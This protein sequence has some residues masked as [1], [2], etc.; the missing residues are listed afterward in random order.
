MSKVWRTLS[1]YPENEVAIYDHD[2]NEHDYLDFQE[3]RY[4]EVTKPVRFFLEKRI[5]RFNLDFVA[6]ST[7]H[8]KLA[9][10]RACNLLREIAGECI[11]F[12]PCVIQNG[13]EILTQYLALNLLKTVDAV[14]HEK[15]EPDFLPI[16]DSEPILI[17]YNHLVFKEEDSEFPIARLSN[18]ANYV[19]VQDSFAEKIIK[20]KLYGVEFVSGW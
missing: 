12:I 7:V 20:N 16:K 10:E 4:I 5:K 19:V 9:N 1:C 2:T 3:S 8:I 18:Y 15:S 11:Q 17:G 13:S 14:D 6:T